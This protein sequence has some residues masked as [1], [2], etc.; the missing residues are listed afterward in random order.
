MGRR[1][2]KL[3]RGQTVTEQR[4]AYKYTN[5]DVNRLERRRA[6]FVTLEFLKNI[7]SMYLLWADGD[8]WKFIPQ[9]ESSGGKNLGERWKE[10]TRWIQKIQLFAGS[11]GQNK[12]CGNTFFSLPLW[13]RRGR[14]W[15]FQ[16][17][18]IKNKC[19]WACRTV[20]WVFYASQVRTGLIAVV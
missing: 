3:P 14:K 16:K 20:Q 7:L 10:N 15:R 4:D 11:G 1:G 6:G 2:L 8:S 13:K 12:Y 5:R 17:Q 18:L 19:V 9:P